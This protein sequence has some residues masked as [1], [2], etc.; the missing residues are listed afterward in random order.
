M[1]QSKNAQDGPDTPSLAP[2]TASSCTPTSLPNPHSHHC[3]SEEAHLALLPSSELRVR[4]SNLGA[5]P[6]LT[7]QFTG[8]QPGCAL[9]L[10]QV[11]RTCVVRQ[12]AV[13]A[14]VLG[15]LHLQVQRCRSPLYRKVRH[16]SIYLR[17]GVDASTRNSCAPRL[18]IRAVAGVEEQARATA[19]VWMAHGAWP[20]AGSQQLPLKP[21]KWLKEQNVWKA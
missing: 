20:R 10:V 1:P 4:G 12:M 7:W 19:D 17:M 15:K 3:K 8:L 13:V 14:R 11:R 18:P 9:P 5:C 6:A 2:N 21:K 16:Y